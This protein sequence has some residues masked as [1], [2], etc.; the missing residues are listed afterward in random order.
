MPNLPDKM[1]PRPFL[2]APPFAITIAGAALYISALRQGKPIGMSDLVAPL[3]PVTASHVAPPV[4]ATIATTEP[5][6]P[7]STPANTKA[8]ASPISTPPPT[9]ENNNAPY[10]STI[11]VYGSILTRIGADLKTGQ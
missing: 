10:A 9:S 2:L 6:T 11:Q 3:P 8:P 7:I 4:P 5:A 1:K